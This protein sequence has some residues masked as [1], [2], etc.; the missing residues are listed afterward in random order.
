[1]IQLKVIKKIEEFPQ[2]VN[3]DAFIEFLYNHLEQFGDS[4]HAINASI[5]YAFFESTR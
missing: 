2:A 4:H 5:D 1:M 3:R